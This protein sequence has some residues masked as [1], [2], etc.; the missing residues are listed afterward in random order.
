MKIIRKKLTIIHYVFIVLVI[1]ALVVYLL[2]NKPV[3]IAF[4]ILIT[5]ISA[6]IRDYV[7]KKIINK[8]RA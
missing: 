5:L 7:R 3:I 1:G 4:V 2:L 8:F 6:N